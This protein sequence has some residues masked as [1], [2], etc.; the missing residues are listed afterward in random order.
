MEAELLEKLIEDT[1]LSDIKPSIRPV[2]EL[3]GIPNLIKLSDYMRSDTLYLPKS[4][5]LL[6][7]ARDRAIRK[8]FNGFNAK[9]LAEKYNLTT[10]QISNI[11]KGRIYG[12]TQLELPLDE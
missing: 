7:P 1:R 12:Y 10:K 9:E 2:A 11:L 4:D 6:M 8:E 5:N 3:I